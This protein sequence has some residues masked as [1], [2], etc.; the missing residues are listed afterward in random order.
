MLW[1]PEAS[2]AVLKLIVAEPAERATGDPLMAL[3]TSSWTVPVGV[4]EFEPLTTLTLKARVALETPQTALVVVRVVTEMVWP[5]VATGGMGV[6]LFQ[7]VARLEA[8]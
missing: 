5:I 3:S 7:S 8:L 2:E 6:T 4:P 1:L